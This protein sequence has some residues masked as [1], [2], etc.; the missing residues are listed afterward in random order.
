MAVADQCRGGGAAGLH[1]T[2]GDAAQSAGAARLGD[3]AA[4]HHGGDCGRLAA[5]RPAPALLAEVQHLLVGVDDVHLVR[6]PGAGAVPA[7]VSAVIATRVK[8]GQEVA[9]RAWEQRIAMAQARSPGF[10]GYRFEPPIPGVQ[11]DWVAI[12]RFDS[13]AQLAEA[14]STHPRVTRCCARQSRSSRSSTRASCARGF[15]QWFTGGAGT[16]PQRRVEAE[17]GRSDDALPDGVPVRQLYADTVAD[18]RAGLP[19]WAALFVGNVASVI[20][21]NWLVPWASQALGWWLSPPKRMRLGVDI[22][23]SVVVCAL[24]SVVL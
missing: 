5:L 17:H 22:G 4:L 19:F 21:L 3:P 6:D 7:P 13:E 20:L 9:F 18:G 15:E 1:R 8:P 12:L 11:D 23:G 2:V 24:Y 14:G 10:Q 16:P